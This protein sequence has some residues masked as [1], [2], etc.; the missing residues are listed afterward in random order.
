MGGMLVRE[1]A[2][3]LVLSG[4]KVLTCDEA[5]AVVAALAIKD[6]RVLAAGD[7][8]AAK[9]LAG[10]RTRVIDLKGRTVVP[11]IIDAHNPLV[12]TGRNLTGLILHGVR[13]IREIQALVAARAKAQPTGTWITGRGWDE[14]LLEAGRA[15]TRRDLDEAAPDPPVVLERVWN[16]LVCNSLALKLAGVDRAFPD[17]PGGE[18]YAGIIGRNAAGEPTGLFTD[19]AKRIIL[20]AALPPTVEAT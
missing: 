13:S 19:R 8:A 2:P 9:G 12:S 5:F 15:P 6:G 7:D 1:R 14:T 20:N 16:K 3:D 11:G 4:G 10:P 17:P 18:R